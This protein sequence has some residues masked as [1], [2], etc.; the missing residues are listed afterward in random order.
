MVKARKAWKKKLFK[1]GSSK[2]SGGDSD[3]LLLGEDENAMSETDKCVEREKKVE[4][5]IE[6]QTKTEEREDDDWEKN[7][8]EIQVDIEIADQW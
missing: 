6:E 4:A 7:N 2:D 1:P 3:S 8:L 5:V